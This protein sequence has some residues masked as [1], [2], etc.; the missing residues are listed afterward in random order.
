MRKIGINIDTLR[1][2]GSFENLERELKLFS[3]MGFDCAELPPAGMSLIF[4]SNLKNESLKKLVEITSRFN[5]LY[6]I[7][8]PDPIN[9]ASRRQ[10]DLQIMI[11]I[12]EI[13][14]AINASVIVYHCAYTRGNKK[15]FEKEVQTIKAIADRLG[16]SILALENTHQMVD[17]VLEVVEA[18]SSEKVKLL[19]DLG[20][21]YIRCNA[22]RSRFFKQIEMGLEKA[23]EIHIHDNFGKQ[24]EGFDESIKNA[25]HFAYLYGVGDLHLP[26]GLGTIPFDEVFNLLR[27]DFDGFVVLEINDLNRFETDIPNS[28]SLLREKL[29]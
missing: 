5:L 22:D 19:I 12:F 23:V 28:L 11:K 16:S 20:H 27:R 29:C 24:S 8:G 9:L 4:N 1:L 18:V 10:E 3:E 6:T 26:L 14:S 13:A 7:H 2:N 17:E 25:T 21:L 15:S